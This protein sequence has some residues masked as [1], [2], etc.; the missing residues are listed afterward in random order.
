MTDMNED[1]MRAVWLSQPTEVPTMPISYLRHRIS[2]LQRRFRLRGM[3]EQGACLV[4]LIWCAVIFAVEQEPW[5][6]AGAALMFLGTCFAIVQWR[7][8]TA[9]R[10]AQPFESATAGLVFYKRELE[11]KRDIH[12]T[13]WRWYLLP[14]FVPGVAFILLGIIFGDLH[15][16][17]Q[18]SPWI[19]LGMMVVIGIVAIA[20]ENIK[21]A[22]YQREIDAIDSM[23]S[24]RD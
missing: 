23:L 1:P 19:M 24:T 8:R 5:K 13:L 3:L 12:R 10:T 4:A 20:Y 11:H 15:S 9:T 16:T 2:E 17:A 18:V 7:R 21:A 14:F 22:Q 6:K